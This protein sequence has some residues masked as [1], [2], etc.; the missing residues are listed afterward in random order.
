MAEY[1][2]RDQ[3]GRIVVGAAWMVESF[4]RRLP[5]VLNEMKTSLLALVQHTFELERDPEGHP[6]EPLK[7]ATVKRRGSAH[8]ILRRSGDLYRSLHPNTTSDSAYIATN[9]PSA[10]AHQFGAAIK[11]LGRKTTLYFKMRR[12]GTVGN[13]FVR[14]DDSDFAQ[15]ASIGPYE[16]T[17]PAR[18]FLFSAGGHFPQP[19]QERMKAIVVRYLKEA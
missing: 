18:P 3:D 16:I 12:D 14:R 10:A 8:P 5:Q 7:P 2:V 19:W 11:R 1:I 9:W 15:D 13:R 17:I 6:W 4:R